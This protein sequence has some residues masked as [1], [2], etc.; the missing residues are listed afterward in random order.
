MSNTI[1]LNNG[2]DSEA[3]TILDDIIWSL[4]G[5]E[6]DRLNGGRSNDRL[7]GEQGSDTLDGGRSNDIVDGGVGDDHLIG[8]RGSDRFIVHAGNDTIADFQNNQDTTDVS[9]A[10]TT[11]A[12][13]KAYVD[14]HATIVA[15]NTVLTDDAANSVTI[16]GVTNITLLYDDI[17]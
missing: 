5:S 9:E 8:G 10:L 4:Y 11:Y 14:S 15:G 7:Y 2:N 17:V 1:N 13:R 3:G 6:N 16:L 12:A